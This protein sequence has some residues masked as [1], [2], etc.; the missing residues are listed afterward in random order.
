MKNSLC[1]LLMICYC[2]TGKSQDHEVDM[3]TQEQL[4]AIVE[5]N[6]GLIDESTLEDLERF[7]RHPVNLNKAK[8]EDLSVLPFINESQAQGFIRYRRLLGDLVNIYELQSV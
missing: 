6:D 1:I 5:R 7:R 2:I 8:E 4:E 3:Q